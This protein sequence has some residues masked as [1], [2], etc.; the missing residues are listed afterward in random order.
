MRSSPPSAVLLVSLAT[1]TGHV[2]LPPCE[3]S[4]RRSTGVN[5]DCSCVPPVLANHPRALS[6]LCHLAPRDQAAASGA[7]GAMRGSH[8]RRITSSSATTLPPTCKTLGRRSH[9]TRKHI[10]A[11]ARAAPRLSA[12]STTQSPRPTPKRRRSKRARSSR[13]ARPQLVQGSTRCRRE[14]RRARAEHCIRSGRQLPAP[15]GAH[16]YAFRSAA[17]SSPFSKPDSASHLGRVLASHRGR[18][19]RRRAPVD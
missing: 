19:C 3:I 16:P 1:P 4:R 17:G 15:L 2:D 7:E 6:L 8:S 5:P 14:I 11:P 9:R 18:A 13:L 12:G 10:A